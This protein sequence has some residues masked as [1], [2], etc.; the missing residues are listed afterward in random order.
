MSNK[1][2]KQQSEGPYPGRGQLTMQGQFMYDQAIDFLSRVKKQVPAMK[3]TVIVDEHSS[4]SVGF[5]ENQMFRNALVAC[6][7]GYGIVADQ[8]PPS[9][10]P[11]LITN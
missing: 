3:I 1:I 6:S 2:K 7:F 8:W 5:A 11:A 4:F 10:E 9:P